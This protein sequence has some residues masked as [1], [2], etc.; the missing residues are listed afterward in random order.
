[1]GAK[2]PQKQERRELF[3]KFLG[4]NEKQQSSPWTYDGM[5]H[6]VDVENGRVRI[7]VLDT[8]WFREEHCIPSVAHLVP[9]GNAIACMTRWLTSGLLLHR[10]AWLWGRDGCQNNQ[11]LGEEQ[12]KWLED[13]LMS[14]SLNGKDTPEL[15]IVA[16]SVQIWST[17]PAMEGWGH[18]PSEQEKM[19]NL[20]RKY[21][22]RGRNNEGK[23]TTSVPVVFLSGDV[24][25]AEI[26][27]QQGYFEITSSGLSK[28]SDVWIVWSCKRCL[29][30]P[31]NCLLS[32]IVQKPIIVGS[33]NYTVVSVNQ[34]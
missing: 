32:L 7:L 34:F 19:W 17:N 30:I 14:P 4:Y 33:R 9:M 21:Y 1:M 18:F 3:W 31:T 29:L 5:Y 22:A 6:R 26:S 2:M 12:W 11:V 13:E 15:F 28:Y 10:I 24:H 20:L 27:G 16:S 23:S 8:R 25:H